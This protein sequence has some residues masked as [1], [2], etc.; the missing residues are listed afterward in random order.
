[1]S[2]TKL[3]TAWEGV[4]P[5][6]WQSDALPI[7]MRS[8]ERGE[9]GMLRAVTGAGKS[10]LIAEVCRM[11]AGRI[12][13]TTPTE[14]LVRD[15]HRAISARNL[16]EC[17]VYYGR[18]KDTSRRITVTCNPSLPGLSATVN[19]P[20]LLLV[21]EAHESECDT[22]LDTLVT[23]TPD[24]IIGVSATP[25]RADSTERLSLYDRL[26]YDYGV[27]AA[28]RDGVIV[29]PRV[30]H[31]RRSDGTVVN[32]IVVSMILRELDRP[33]TGPG[34]V[35]AINITDALDFRDILQ[36]AG[37]R[38]EVVHSQQRRGV[39]DST[40][41]DL[42]SGMLDCVVHVAML[43][44]GVDIP[45]L[46]WICCR[47]PI[48]S[49]TL[50]AQYVGRGVRNFP[51]KTECRV[52]DPMDLLNKHGLE[53]GAVLGAGDEVDLP[54]AMVA[55]RLDQIVE[56]M[57]GTT[58]QEQTT[59]EGVP[60]RVLDPAAAYLRGVRFAMECSGH[61]PFD[62]D[63]GLWRREKVS[64]GQ[65][66]TVGPKMR[67]LNQLRRED[68]IPA[69]HARALWIAYRALPSMKAGDAADLN[70][71]LKLLSWKGWPNDMEID[72]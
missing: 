49:S 20:D 10:Y 56:S 60:V 32:D 52:L 4:E 67:I 31:A 7:V 21:D 11:T 55:L 43:S 38:A 19:A 6:Q 50:F 1:M 22:F 23:W 8:I 42:E 27:T 24:A 3:R 47:R 18:E 54:P 13:V 15:L 14:K 25:W 35:D 29:P 66:A 30:V 69:E 70:K 57:D 9:R 5:R 71:I 28:I 39:V 51:G 48:G 40:L 68:A 53:M 65:L 33:D 58:E 59:L 26:I 44:R 62:H 12:V 63:L 2:A 61:L 17:G 16:G 64:D 46:R 41:A 34:I 72:V 37:V 45:C 36:R